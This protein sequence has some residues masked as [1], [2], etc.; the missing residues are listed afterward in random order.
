MNERIKRTC[1]TRYVCSAAAQICWC[2]HVTVEHSD[3]IFS[4]DGSVPFFLLARSIY[5]WQYVLQ[6]HD[7]GKQR[8]CYTRILEQL[9]HRSPGIVPAI[10]HPV[11]VPA[12][13]YKRARV[14]PEAS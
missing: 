12:S 4:A 2:D 8:I 1:I 3:T 13:T 7:I 10:H 5:G 9:L 11:V 14:F 6:H